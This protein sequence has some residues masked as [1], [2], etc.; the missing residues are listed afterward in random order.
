M[1]RLFRARLVSAM[2]S[3]APALF[4]LAC[5]SA[6]LAGPASSPPE[7]AGAP[8]PEEDADAGIPC[9]PSGVSKG[10]WVVGVTGSAA[11]I[12][13][14]ACRA[15]VSGAVT[16]APEAG[17]ESRTLS[18]KESTSVITVTHTA[19]LNPKATPDF[20]GTW[21]NHE[22]SAASLLPS[23]CY[24]YGLA[25]DKAA[26]G[27][28]C[29]ARKS[30]EPLRFFAIGD[31]NPNLGDTTEQVLAR[32]IPRGFDF[33][34]HLG[35]IQYYDSTLETWASWSPRVAPML[36][37][38]AFFP[39]IGNHEYEKPSEYEDYVRRYFGRTG[40]PGND[41]AYRFE[42]GGVH[43]FVLATEE[44][45]GPG[46]TQS[47][48]FEEESAKVTTLP[49][50]RFSVVY[51]HRP[52]VSCGDEGDNPVA[53]TFYEPLFVQNKVLLVLQGHLHAYERFELGSVTYVTSGGGG[54][55]PG[56]PNKN[57][58]RD[59]CA[60]RKSAGAFHH[61]VLLEV[62][63]PSLRGTVIDAAGGVRDTFERAVP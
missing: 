23:T 26:T 57:L 25:A 29:T 28:F 43:F 33:T 14:E 13:F 42:S 9:P 54:G 59:Y 27:R 11:S 1:S 38:G 18:S 49:G 17:G 47:K 48:W 63:G 19:P 37:Q 58:G 46:S 2:V 34:L 53:R 4:M 20:A 31:T 10:P 45:I 52:F 61:G 12:R 32:A 50:F 56:D 39:S 21:Y 51:F 30:G 44:A 3:A 24:R 16:L 35:D 8:A 62:E 40:L 22:V 60:S 55:R 7:E 41:T 5:G 6:P 36:R 15:G